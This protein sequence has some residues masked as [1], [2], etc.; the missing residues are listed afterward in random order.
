M[1]GNTT[2][3]PCELPDVQSQPDYRDIALDRV[4]VTK[5]H[6][7]LRILQKDRRQQDVTA[8]IDLTVGLHHSQRGAH[9][10]SLIEILHDRRDHI[11]TAH[12][13]AD[14]L[15]RIRTQ[16]DTRGGQRSDRAEVKALFKFFT[17]KTAPVSGASA[18][19]AYDCGFHATLN[20]GDKGVIVQAQLATLCP[21]SLAIS[22]LGAHN[23]RAT[24]TVQLW[25]PLNSDQPIWLEDII[26]L[27]ESSGSA[28][29]HS[30]LKRPDEKAITE[31]IF[32]TPR[33]VEDVVREIAAKLHSQMRSVRYSVACESLESIHAHNAYAE[34]NGAC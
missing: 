30:V 1:P 14:L 23:Q 5:L 15:H 7:P 24:A 8:T 18:L 21:C 34:V 9:L 31:R 33:F 12:D 2:R 10:S 19:V 28:P 25:Q 32:R 6:Y 26:S 22:D 27:I 11:A 3:I 13:L 4:G 16:Q 17:S 29:V 20:P